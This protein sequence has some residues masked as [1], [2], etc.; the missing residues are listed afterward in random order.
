MCVSKIVYTQQNMDEKMEIRLLWSIGLSVFLALSLTHALIHA[1]THTHSL[2]VFF[3]FAEFNL[4]LINNYYELSSFLE[5]K[6]IVIV[7]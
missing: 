4:D 5:F 6:G 7:F 2:D 3:L 1:R